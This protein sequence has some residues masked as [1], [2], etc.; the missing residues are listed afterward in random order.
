MPL[1]QLLAM[2]GYQVPKGNSPAEGAGV[3]SPQEAES[4]EQVVLGDPSTEGE[5][6]KGQGM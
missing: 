2:Y 3:P 5:P 4:I 1:E 6:P